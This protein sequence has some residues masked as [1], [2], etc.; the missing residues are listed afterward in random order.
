LCGEQIIKNLL[1]KANNKVS[2]PIQN[3]NGD[4]EFG[5]KRFSMHD[6]ELSQEDIDEVSFK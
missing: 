5:G 3:D 6:E 1:E 2:Y 4:I